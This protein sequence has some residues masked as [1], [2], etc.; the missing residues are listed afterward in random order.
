M[1]MYRMNM[2]SASL[3]MRIFMSVILLISLGLLTVYAESAD[4][5]AEEILAEDNAAAVET[6]ADPV[7]SEGASMIGEPDEWDMIEEDPETESPETESAPALYAA[8]AD[9]DPEDGLIEEV[10]GSEPDA[11]DPEDIWEAIEALE[12]AVGAFAP[13]DYE[14]L[15]PQ[16]EEMI[17][18]SVSYREGSMEYRDGILF[19]RDDQ[20]LNGY[21]PSDRAREN[22]YASVPQ[23]SGQLE[24]L[25]QELEET[26]ILEA[27]GGGA[28]T[29]YDVG[30]FLPY[31]GYDNDIFGNLDELKDVIAA[32]TGGDI[33]V[34]RGSEASIDRLAD[35]IEDCTVILIGSHGT[36][37]GGV[38]IIHTDAGL[39]QSDYNGGHAWK[40][41]SGKWAIDGT[42]IANH[43]SK[44]AG[45]CF[46]YSGSCMGMKTDRLCVPLRNK[47]VDVLLGYSE[48]VSSGGMDSFITA[49]MASL[50][51]GN[52]A[53]EAFR[54]MKRASG[55]DWDPLFPTLSLQEA[56]MSGVAFP[57]LVSDQDPYPGQGNVN[58]IQDV[59]ST[60]KLPL[61]PNPDPTW[62]WTVK[63][64]T[65][66]QQTVFNAEVETAEAYKACTCIGGS[67]PAG[68]TWSW[69]SSPGQL[70]LSGTPTQ[71][72]LSSAQFRIT[73]AS[74]K[75]YINN[76]KIMVRDTA[77]KKSSQTIIF[78][79]PKPEA[80][81]E[82][83]KFL[84]GS[85]RYYESLTFPSDEQTYS[86]EVISGSL[87]YSLDCSFSDGSNGYIA[88][89]AYTGYPGYYKMTAPGTYKA[90]LEIIS[91]DGS[92][93]HHTVTVR[94][95]P[96][97][98]YVI[99]TSADPLK[100]TAKENEAF[101]YTFVHQQGVDDREWTASE[102]R[103]IHLRSDSGPLSGGLILSNTYMNP[104]GI[105]GMPFEAGTFPVIVSIQT[106]N[107]SFLYNVEITV[108]PSDKKCGEGL[109]WSL[110]DDL[111]LRIT[112]TPDGWGIM[113][114]FS[115]LSPGW[116][117]IGGYVKEVRIGSGVVNITTNAFESCNS[118]SMIVFEAEAPNISPGAFNYVTA[119]AYYDSSYSGWDSFDFQGYGGNITWKDTNPSAGS[120]QNPVSEKCGDGVIWSLSDDGVLSIIK[121]G[122]LGTMWDFSNSTPAWASL[123]GKVKE[124]HIGS[125]VSNISSYAFDS[126][127]NLKKVVF[128]GDAP[129]IAMNGFHN[130]NVTVYYD[131]ACSGWD[132]F[133]FEDYGG[134]ITW[135]DAASPEG[136]TLLKPKAGK[137][138]ITVKWNKQTEKTTGYQIQVSLKK[139]FPDSKKKTKLITITNNATVRRKVSG[140]KSR[141]KYYIRIRTFREVNGK[142]YYSG[143]SKVKSIKTK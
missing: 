72:G 34:W 59:K 95:V 74:G 110:S 130:R 117:P 92:V 79:P 90:T 125:G 17:L 36:D 3:L 138:K 40:G 139:S 75:E 9:P 134:S 101:S 99:N 11:D 45:N 133:L 77:V 85:E 89:T 33:T 27:A 44:N 131:S 70:T 5:A 137:K 25:T 38:F 1:S 43:M 121:T 127:S 26:M 62:G 48:S 112:K 76:V 23:T 49:F 108:E 6:D 19:W 142:Y 84:K 58:V 55:C 126:C 93:F 82:F 111:V 140:L 124:V 78:T 64:V 30:V 12:K 8:D 14:A 13:E 41:G 122:G 22:G 69:K 103:V 81:W 94:V 143:W 71:K 21:S 60:W 136:T 35:L 65:K 98:T 87:P 28:S 109:V 115:S 7:L 119:T 15:L 39:T 52:T 2:K 105:Y 66:G 53:A 31:D 42:V 29:G 32:Y 107:A 67:M 50:G 88:A 96:D 24:A 132:S 106:Y 10:S 16:I 114:N 68:I 113:W 129:L 123:G 80:Q 51:A 20:C 97:Y 83:K 47:G 116:G 91:N 86:M 37:P 4:I 54:F 18:S 56:R 104:A 118:L 102:A 128:E 73:T 100:L 141:K 61:R 120:Q 135:T 63:T 57:I 46:V